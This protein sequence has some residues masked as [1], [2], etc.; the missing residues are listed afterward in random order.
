[1]WT[2]DRDRSSPIGET[3]KTPTTVPHPSSRY[4]G[5][6]DRPAP[7]INLT[8]LQR[9]KVVAVVGRAEQPRRRCAKTGRSFEAI[10]AAGMR[11]PGVVLGSSDQAAQARRVG[12]PVSPG[13]RLSDGGSSR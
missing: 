12:G 10:A 1:M 8:P 3:E 2:C 4:R 7:G 13:G 6:S 11:Q 5:T 9:T